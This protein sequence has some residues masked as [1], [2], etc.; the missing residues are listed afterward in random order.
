MIMP[1]LENYPW[2]RWLLFTTAAAAPFVLYWIQAATGHPAWLALA[3]VP[4]AMGL[5]LLSLGEGS[6]I[7]GLTVLIFFYTGLRQEHISGRLGLWFQIFVLTL[8]W[9]AVWLFRYRAGQEQR[10]QRDYL[11]SLEERMILA[12]EQYKNDLVL[13][14]SNQRKNQ[15][16]FLLN[17]VTRV[18]GSQLDM[19]KLADVVMHELQEILGP[20]RGCYMFAYLLGNQDQPLIR[21]T[22]EGLEADR[23]LNDQFATW[24]RQHTTTLLVTDTQKDFR[25]RAESKQPPFRS[26]MI[27]PLLFGG[28][29]T[30]VVRAESAYPGMFTPDDLRLLTIVGDL[31][32]AAA[33]NARLYQCTH[34][35]AITDGLTGLYLRRFFNQRLEEELNRFS[36]YRIP[37]S[38]LLLDLDHF[39]RI[40]DRLGHPVGDHVLSQLAEILR[41][42]ARVMDIL[43]RFGGEEF[44]LLL[45]DTPA[46]SG[47]I[48][49]ER[50]RRQVGRRAFQQPQGDLQITVSIGVAGCPEHGQ[51]AAALIKSADE[52]LYAAKR[53]GRNR[54]CLAGVTA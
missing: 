41:T 54:V 47:L 51:G 14:V 37:F 34:E 25:F 50:I 22:P 4:A 18:F 21:S 15:K 19:T 42:E 23:I 38:L 6:V 44:A 26:V 12:R 2:L 3:L 10:A 13:N 16:Y 8:C 31:A 49:A 29:V 5:G 46:P 28:R 27:V 24:A 9:G 43:C 1:Y 52:A 35:L 30:G 39:K 7:F 17:R 20:E 48:M 32:G 11:S 40:N 36:A 33:E 53:Q 45:P